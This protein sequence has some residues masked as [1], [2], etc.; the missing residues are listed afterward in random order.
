LTTPIILF[1]VFGACFGVFTYSN[2]HLFSE[3]PTRR[4]DAG[5]RPSLG[6][7]LMW[8]V[9]CACLWPVMALT[10]LYSLWHLSRV[11]VRAERD[12]HRAQP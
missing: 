7:R 8:I 5:S 12:K 4:D 6:G 1:F 3:G 10:G 2:R 9:T 11:R